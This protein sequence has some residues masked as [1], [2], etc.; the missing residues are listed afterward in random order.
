MAYLVALDKTTGV[1][2]WRVDRPNR[3]R[4]YCPPLLIEAAGKN[5]TGPERQQ[6]AS[7]ATIRTRGRQFWLIDG[8][9]EQFVASLVYQDGILFLTAGFPT[10]HLMGIHPDGEG[11]ITASRYIAWHHSN[12][13]STG[14]S[15]V[16]SPIALGHYFLVV[17]D[18]GFLHCLDTK[19]G[20][21]LWKERLGPHHSASPVAADGYA[22]FLDDEG[23]TFIVKP[24]PQCAIVARNRLDEPCSASPAVAHG[25]LFIRTHQSLYCIGR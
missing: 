5:A 15:Y 19:T 6:V 11:N 13:G 1:E 10:F 8:P 22:Y 4:S 17:A 24:G 23:T 2:R 12:V 18:T 9:T 25:H 3:T 7:P 21:R 20:K 14:A 16:P